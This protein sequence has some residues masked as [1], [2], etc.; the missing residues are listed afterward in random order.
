MK[1]ESKTVA[2]EVVEAVFAKEALLKSKR[3]EDRRD[4]L[5]FLLHDGES[6]SHAQVEKI[7][8]DYYGKV[9]G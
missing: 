4:A 5:S 7:L 1:S 3:Y 6:Y 2:P 9:V 8:N